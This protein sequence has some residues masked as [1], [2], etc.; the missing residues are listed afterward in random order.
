VEMTP[1]DR[2][3]DA[4]RIAREAEAIYGESPE[5]ALRFLRGLAGERSGPARVLLAPVLARV[6]HPESL[7][8]LLELA[9]DPRA[10]VRR[11]VL[12]ALKALAAE[13]DGLPAA[14]LARAR[15]VLHE[16]KAKG[17]WVF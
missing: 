11:E 9:A 15:A 14:F 2:D 3:E 1:P 13:P 8:L 10:E 5:E 7:D 16:E 17:E 6:R 12:K 4:G